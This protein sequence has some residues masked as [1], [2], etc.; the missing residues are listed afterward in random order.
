MECSPSRRA[1]AEPLESRMLLTATVSGTPTIVNADKVTGPQQDPTIVSNPTNPNQ[2]YM[3]AD[4]VGS[5]LLTS[6]SSNG[7]ATWTPL[8][9]FTGSDGFPPASIN[10]TA[11][12]D[13]Y[14]N[15][16]VA[17]KRADTGSTEV[18]YSYDNGQTFHVLASL[19]GNSR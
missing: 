16:F 6:T 1:L 3:V 10:P 13:S 2:M 8:V 19:S 4:N 5:S 11:A 18:L 9:R 17:Y 14:G 7:G 12:Y 15:L